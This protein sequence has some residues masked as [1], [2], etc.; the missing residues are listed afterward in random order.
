MLNNFNET[1]N[2]LDKLIN[3]EDYKKFLS[4]IPHI[5]IKS[6]TVTFGTIFKHEHKENF[7][8]DWLAYLLD[9]QN[10]GTTEPLQALIDLAVRENKCDIDFSEV[11]IQ[12]EYVFDNDKRRIDFLITTPTH[13]IGIENK[14]WSDLGDNQLEDYFKQITAL[15]SDYSQNNKDIQTVLIFLCPE[16]NAVKNKISS[17]FKLVT[18][19][20]LIERFKKIRLNC[21]ENLR[22]SILMEDF[23]THVEGY[24]MNNI[25]TDLNFDF[26]QFQNANQE[27]INKL[28]NDIK[29][30]KKQFKA[31]VKREIE[32]NG[33]NGDEW[34]VV[35]KDGVDYF[36][37]IYKTH[38]NNG[39][40]HFEFLKEKN[41][42]P[43]NDI[44]VVFHIEGRSEY[45][46]KL[47]ELR[48]SKT[49][50]IN[51]KMCYDSQEDFCESIKNVI[52]AL[53][54]LDEQF[55]TQIDAIFA[56]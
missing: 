46:D 15:Q 54:E 5:E 20:E 43:P 23:I 26:M 28:N 33:F 2:E 6:P 4:E 10:V 18:Y 19:D 38:W 9:P 16:G 3:K 29:E 25:N 21:L 52:N 51:V 37:Q 17:N 45:N 35:I 11:T 22:A 40:T 27:I 24:F 53:K 55:T 56:E 48:K 32:K 49:N 41:S 13:I 47:R 14:I 42:F 44:W 12:R 30:S 8:S 7:I 50:T 39:Y 36:M 31:F 1:I 34:K